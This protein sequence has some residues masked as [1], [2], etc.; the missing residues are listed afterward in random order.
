MSRL[1]RFARKLAVALVSLVAFLVVLELVARAAEPGPFSLFDRNPYEAHERLRHV[2]QPGFEG[3]WDGTWYEINALGLRG[4]EIASE[5]AEQ[6]LRVVCLGDS[7]TFGKG[8]VEADTWPR[9]LERML[10]EELPDETVRVANLGVNGYAGRDYREAFLSLG[11][12]LEPDVVVVGYNLNDFPNSVR[13]VDEAVFRRSGAR[14]L[15]PRGTRDALGRSALYRWLR[16][17]YYDA[18]RERDWA[19]A[20]RFARE[21]GRDRGDPAVWA[22][23]EESLRALRDAAHAAGAEIAVF[24]FPYES[25]V[26]RDSFDRTPIELL[27]ALCGR[28]E[29]PFVSLEQEFRAWA[30]ESEPPRELF[31]RGDRYHPRPAGYRLV[32]QRVLALLREHGWLPVD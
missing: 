28:L 23:E 15:L 6:E 29:I 24:L 20:E 31:L 9:Q 16:A 11:L 5:A 18:Q 21:A 30:H 32:A 8:V 4:P 25:Q 14:A 3:R 26:Y 1:R 2:H 17:T 12:E 13:A 22:A 7:C 19:N 27:T 10:R